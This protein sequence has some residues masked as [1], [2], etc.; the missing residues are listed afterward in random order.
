MSAGVREE[1]CSANMASKTASFVSRSV[2]WVRSNKKNKQKKD[3]KYSV[4]QKKQ[5]S[6]WVLPFKED[7][8]EGTGKP[9]RI[10]DFHKENSHSAEKKD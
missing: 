1:A 9:A 8:S 10:E 6:S 2:I 5:T 4:K 7:L 3:G